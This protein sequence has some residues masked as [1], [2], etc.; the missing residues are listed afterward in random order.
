MLADVADVEAA[1]VLKIIKV[2]HTRGRD[3]RG[4]D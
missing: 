4:T 1:I 2:M 3:A